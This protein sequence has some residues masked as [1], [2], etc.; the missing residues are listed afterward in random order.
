[1]T[2]CRNAVRFIPLF[3]L[4]GTLAVAQ[5]ANQDHHPPEDA[6]QYIRVLD[7][8][9]RNAWQ[10][11]RKVMT[12]LGLKPGNRVADL[13]SG[14]GYF[15]FRFA[16]TVGPAGTVYAVDIS[17]EMLD[18][19]EKQS[20]AEHLTNIQPIL[21]EPHNPKLP[22][23]SVD[24]IFICDTLHHISDRLTYYPF[25]IRALK[26]GGRF[27]NIDF[28]KRPLP[29]GP[30]VDEKIA[31]ADMIREAESAGFHL[32]RQYDF[33]KYQYFLVFRR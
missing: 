9:S 17:R 30:S 25:L 18:Y 15:T 32:V 2:R 14:P 21:A 3:L 1:M 8:P 27:V 26:P 19:L 6:G 5:A 11:P 10:Q 7:S 22:P 12:A 24:V 16:R 29:V 31:K 13:G 33:L 20:Q 23:A 4:A 28:Y